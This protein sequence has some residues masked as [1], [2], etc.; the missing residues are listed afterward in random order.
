MGIKVFL[1]TDE[2]PTPH[3]QQGPLD[4]LQGAL[5]CVWGGLQLNQGYRVTVAIDEDRAE[6]YLKFIVAGD[7]KVHVQV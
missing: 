6:R 4:S 3:T 2:L 7:A 1:D 5:L